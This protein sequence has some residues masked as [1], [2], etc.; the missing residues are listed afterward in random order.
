ML[1]NGLPCIAIDL[2]RDAHLI[3]GEMLLILHKMCIR[4]RDTAGEVEK[5]E[6]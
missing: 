4:D 1:C 2:Q 3:Y 6:V 5:S